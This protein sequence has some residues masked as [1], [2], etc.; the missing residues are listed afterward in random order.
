MNNKIDTRDKFIKTASRLFQLK[1][2]QGTGLNEILR[3]SGAPRGSLYH[4]FPNGKEELALEAIKFLSENI[5][6]DI[7]NTLEQF[8]DPVEAI[9]VHIEKIAKFITNEEKL[10]D[11]SISLLALETYSLSECLRKTCELAFALFENMYVEKLILGGFTEEK[12][13]ELSIVIQSMIEGA[14]TL[15]LTKKSGTPLLA[16]AKQISVLLS[17]SAY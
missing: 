6:K 13:E 12:A 10:Q 11:F 15:S 1:G 17:R 16:V 8:S 14:I 3:E 4:H 7:K 2:Y 9:Q 5:Q